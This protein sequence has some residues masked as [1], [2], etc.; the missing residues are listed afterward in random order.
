[1]QGLG[2]S[3]TSPVIKTM[4]GLALTGAPTTAEASRKTKAVEALTTTTADI[5]EL[6]GALLK[7]VDQCTIIEE[8]P[9]YIEDPIRGELKLHDE[10]RPSVD[11]IDGT[12]WV[13][14]GRDCEPLNDLSLLNDGTENPMFAWIAVQ[15]VTQDTVD[16]SRL[17]FGVY[18][19]VGKEPGVRVKRS[20]QVETFGDGDT[21]QSMEW[22]SEV[23]K[24][25]G[26][27]QGITQV[28]LL[29]RVVGDQQAT[30]RIGNTRK[31]RKAYQEFDIDV[32]QAP[33]ISS[34][35]AIIKQAAAI[36]ALEDG[37]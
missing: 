37:Y 27:N 22:V 29:D 33:D 28:W 16:G 11:V 21:Q 1:M 12:K 25:G 9:S 15:N 3:I 26:D 13:I 18:S 2:R 36:T 20:G 7:A 6:A 35:Q 8:T 5:R 4:V 31:M 19:T 17:Q 23:E 34:V 14:N 30:V 24:I 32:S 10:Q